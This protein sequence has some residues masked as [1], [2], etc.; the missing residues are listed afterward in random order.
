MLMLT[1]TKNG[2]KEEM[3]GTKQLE[4][5]KK[6]KKE[7]KGSQIRHEA[8]RPY[9]CMS[10]TLIVPAEAYPKA[11]LSLARPLPSHVKLIVNCI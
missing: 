2:P 6:K 10:R 1:S 5:L 3:D 11:A 7:K 8:A 9:P 4:H